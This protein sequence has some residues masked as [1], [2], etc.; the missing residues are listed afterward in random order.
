MI[1]YSAQVRSQALFRRIFMPTL[2][3]RAA[4]TPKELKTRLEERKKDLGITDNFSEYIEMMEK[5][6]L[7]LERRVQ[8][9]EKDH[10]LDSNDIPSAEA[11]MINN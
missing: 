4:E 3:E 11:L 6:L 9:I 5:Y 2:E 7:T 1:R 10:N 8:R